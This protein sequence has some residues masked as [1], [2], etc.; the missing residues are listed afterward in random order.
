MFSIV[1]QLLYF[2]ENNADTT[3]GGPGSPAT[4]DGEERV[5]CL[6]RESNPSGVVRSVAPL[7]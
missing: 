3:L 4:R 2:K 6:Y 7:N 1:L 5:L